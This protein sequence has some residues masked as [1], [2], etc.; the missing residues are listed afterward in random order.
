[1][2]GKIRFAL[3]TVFLLSALAM[4][5]HAWGQV[6]NVTTDQMPPIPG[7]GY[8]YVH[9]LVETIDPQMGALSLRFALPV[10]P[11]RDMKVPFTLAYDS[12]LSLHFVTNVGGVGVMQWTD[13]A[14]YLGRGG[15]H[16]IVPSLGVMDLTYF[17]GS[18]PGGN[19][20]CH[21]FRNYIF[22]D[23]AGVPHD[24][25]LSQSD[26]Q[27]VCQQNG[28]PPV[29]QKLTGTDFTAYM[30]QTTQMNFN[31]A[32]P[33]PVT[34]AG[35]DGTVYQFSNAL[36]RL[37]S[38]PGDN[39]SNLH[40]T[41]FSASLVSALPDLIETR[42]GNQ[43]T[44]SD[45]RGGAFTVTD[46]L[47][48]SA[49]NTDGF[50]STGSGGSNN[51]TIS[52]I[53]SFAITWGSP[54][55]YNFPASSQI[56]ALNP[57][58]GPC[59][60]GSFSS[61]ATGSQPEVTQLALP[62]NQSYQFQYDVI[63]GLV[64]QITYPSGAVV[65]YTWAANPLAASSGYP[66]I[67][68]LNNVCN[69]LYDTPAVA[70][71]VVKPDGVHATLEQDFIYSTTWRSDIPPANGVRLWTTKQTTVI[72][73]DLITGTSFKTVYTYSS[74][75]AG[76]NIAQ[77]VTTATYDGSANNANLL[78]TN[79]KIWNFIGLPPSNETVSL[80]NGLTRQAITCYSGST[81]A[82]CQAPTI[83]PQIE[84]PTDQYEYDYGSGASGAILRHT[85]TDYAAFASTPLNGSI[86]DRP[87]DT[88][89]YD[90]SGNRVSETDYVYDETSLA[91]VTATAHDD[92]NY[93]A[94]FRVR[95]NATTVT[96]K[97][98]ALAA[99]QVCPDATTI[100]TYDQTGQLATRKDPNGNITAYSYTDNFTDAPSIGNTNAYLTQITLPQT[101][102]VA[103]TENF[104]YIYSDGQ[105]SVERDQNGQKTKFLYNDTLH[106]LT[107][108]DFPD[109]GSTTLAYH[110]PT[111]LS[112]TTTKKLDS[113]TNIQS[114][115][116]MDGMG[117]VIQTQL[118]SDPAG[119][120][121]VDTI[122]DG[123][124]LVISESNP[125]RS[126]SA[127][128][129]GITQTQYD[130][131]GRITETIKPDGSA[132]RLSY[133][134]NCV[135]STDET[136]KPRKSCSDALGNTIEVDEPNVASTG[137]NATASLTIGGS[138]QTANS[139]VDSG[140]VSLTSGGFT[141]T[142]C[143]GNSTNSLCSNMPINN[144][145]AQVAAALA[146]N[147]NNTF[148][149]PIT[150][151][152]SGATLNL[153]WNTPGPFY[154]SVAALNTTRD[155][156]SL[157]TN[158]SFTSQATMFDHG[159]GPSFDTDPYVTLYQYDAL[160]N[161]ICVEQ[162]GGV[163]G[164]GCSADSSLD[165]SS[166]WRVRRFTYDSLSRLLTAKNPESGTITYFYD[167]NG[168]LTQK[169]MPSPNQTGTA[170]HTISYCYDSLNRV[171]GKA[172]SWQNCQNGQLPSGTAA[173]TYTYDE[174]TNGIGRLTSLTDQAGSA[175]YNYD[176]LGRMSSENRTINGVT[177]NMSYTY[178]LDG[179]VATVAYPS[180]TPNGPPGDV[181]TYT[182]DAAGHILSV[183]DV[184]NNINYVTGATYNAPGMLTGSTYGQ[185]ASFTGIVNQVS[186]NIRLQPVN[187]WSSSP[188][189]TL[190]DL[191]YDFQVWIGDNGNVTRIINNRDQSRNRIFTYDPLNRLTSAQNAGTDCSLTLLD[192]KTKFWGNNYVYDAWG[193]LMQKQVTKCQA[194]NLNTGVN[195]FNRLQSFDYDSAGN[196]TKDN[197]GTSYVLD[198]ENRIS[199][200]ST[201]FSYAYD[202][203]GNR[204]QK[205][206]GNVTPAT[207]TLYWYMSAG[208]VA[209]SDFL[210]NLQSEY[211]FFNG[212][213]VARKDFPGNAISYYF[214]DHLKTA[215]VITDAT[216][217]IK[218]ESDYYPWGGE[219]QIA[220]GDS[221][222]Y[223]FTGKE[224]DA[225]T[226]LDYFGARYYG[227]GLGRF[228][229][230][231]EPFVDQDAQDPQS[232]NLYSYVRNN[233]GTLTDVDGRTVLVCLKT[234]DGAEECEA[235]SNDDYRRAR[236]DDE[237]LGNTAPPLGESGEI[238]CGGL[239]CGHAFF[240][241]CPACVADGIIPLN[242]GP[243]DLLLGG[244][245]RSFFRSLSFDAERMAAVRA[246]GKA[247]EAAADIVKNTERIPSKTGT[248]SYRVP[249]I[250]D[251]AKKEIGDV[252][253]Y[254]GK[255]SY[256]NQLKDIV[257]FATENK[258]QVILKVPQG[259]TLTGPLQQLVNNGTI[260]LVRF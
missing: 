114:T 159:V 218:S 71:R 105:L 27:V 46:Q 111:P 239:V 192:G 177:K 40:F 209:E 60:P 205:T 93:P 162:H 26:Q 147:F 32:T 64:N 256:T 4:H 169:A 179:S 199:S 253:N 206:N 242:L 65:S 115:A 42:N 166:P 44:I 22:T 23:A 63:T 134:G 251:K 35:A 95:G 107:E 30:A 136:A 104:S 98:F 148:A 228:L 160:G 182:P 254:T 102:T 19:T 187:L 2:T 144:T 233:P 41:A 138:L 81:T 10:P 197:N 87:S 45:Q 73:K 13:N 175:T 207:G 141:A 76:T 100:L 189:K 3:L 240:I 155:Q 50:G 212:E 230:P 96:R 158:P 234:D 108:T 67:S 229:T 176:I 62:N 168:N 118:N 202:A 236:Q 145:T 174:R 252:K 194:E 58:G 82:P 117:R 172:Y 92:I 258:F 167:N 142:A 12:N 154:P 124:G 24:V 178:N 116:V 72:T 43:I 36:S 69:I 85:H 129:D 143:Y 224:R 165:N 86:M 185:S 33:P 18:G 54:Q 241:P 170:Q 223:K 225:E 226:G 250:L 195:T 31:Q 112:I 181:I 59:A 210:G 188:T 53:G 255:V 88:I 120:D 184:G 180:A 38:Y 119:V 25:S 243:G 94:G 66:Q 29:P 103:H 90:G 191:I 68:G 245:G 39:S 7:S 215:S 257:A 83:F 173:V 48:R 37:H 47:S 6:A 110:D 101:G 133:S 222:H 260:K 213:R 259:A 122:H 74:P 56:T 8:D 238:R 248:A 244:F 157:F 97:C 196:M 89:T 57:N 220:N 132:T 200:T 171:T 91:S 151:T 249:D 214:S 232:W 109:G 125:H 217:T 14:G 20:P 51:I 152:A 5:P 9:S 84:L 61:T 28:N 161:L 204:V 219:L 80:E 149:S 99:N 221:N 135:T 164:T 190:M 247:G 203:D 201:G 163:S 52:G 153:V 121:Y 231:D 106:R 186:F 128:T 193:N 227:N 131:L 150:A 183:K 235:V 126:T 113:S 146:S 55:S 198:A 211:V 140:I 208:I 130:A 11:G 137:T 21:Y 123:L 1:M 17:A 15:W 77:Q 127:L 70:S 237:E 78:Q 79:T 16:Y 75:Q 156:P 34:V 49:I 246:T 216:G 139:T